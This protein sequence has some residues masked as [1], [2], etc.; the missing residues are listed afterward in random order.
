MASGFPSLTF[1][2]APKAMGSSFIEYRK[3]GFGSHDAFIENFAR[4]IA[5]FI[6][7]S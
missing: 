1:A 6:D 2:S 5:A 7:G 4:E 3:Q